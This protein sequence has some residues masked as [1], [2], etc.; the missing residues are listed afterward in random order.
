MDKKQLN[1]ILVWL[2]IG[3]AIGS[4][5]WLGKSKKWKWILKK[6]NQD[7]KEWLKEMKNFFQ[8]LKQ[9]YAKKK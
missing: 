4:A 5:T 7:I 3:T 1:K 9:K 2:F 6:I 8:T